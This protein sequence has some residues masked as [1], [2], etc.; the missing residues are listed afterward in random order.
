VDTAS[1]D[2]EE[3]LLRFYEVLLAIPEELR[4][5]SHSPFALNPESAEGFF[6]LIQQVQARTKLPPALKGQIVG[7]LTFGT[8]LRDQ[9]GKANFL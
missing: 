9:D 1:A 3:S 2:F 7:P 8:T 5:W 4:R 6:E